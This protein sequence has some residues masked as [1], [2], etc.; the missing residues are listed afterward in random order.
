MT[1]SYHDRC[2]DAPVPHRNPASL[3]RT[4]HAAP[5]VHTA[6]PPGE[7]PYP[8]R[9]QDDDLLETSIDSRVL[10]RGRYVT[11]RQETIEDARGGRHSRDWVEHPGAVAMLPLLEG[12]VLMV[13]QF[14]TPARRVL[15]EIPA[16]TL[17][18]MPDGSIEDPDRAAPR[19]LGEET[20][21]E[22]RS[23]RKLGAF[24]PAPGFASEFMHLYLATDLVAIE[25]Y[26]GPEPDERINVVRMPLAEALA[27]ADAG[28][29]ED[30][31]TMIGLYWLDRLVRSGEV[32][33]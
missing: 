23:W 2:L 15:L 4:A 16:G 17:D 20:G 9:M 1:S 3:H 26:S 32:S 30:G 11:F 33:L 10:H 24:Y 19:E 28:G 22:A 31:K 27:L 6:A 21:Y 18:R 29:I 14:R 25:G 8:A 7:G 5:G 13:R 12:D